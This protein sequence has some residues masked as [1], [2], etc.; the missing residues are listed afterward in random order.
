MC[1]HMAVEILS[2]PNKYQRGTDEIFDYI[3]K[4]GHNMTEVGATVPQMGHLGALAAEGS[5]QNVLEIGFNA[6]CS[7]LAFLLGSSA[8]LHVVS[9][10]IGKHPYVHDAKKFIDGKFPGRHELVIGNSKHTVPKYA[11]EHPG[12]KFD[13]IFIDGGHGYRYAK[14]DL[15]NCRLLAH[16]ST[17]VI[18]DDLVPG[19]LWSKGPTRAWQRAIDG[20]W[21]EEI[22]RFEDGQPVEHIGPNAERGWALGR[23][24]FARN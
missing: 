16:E 23:Y 20:G 4:L 22:G 19:R 7:S 17:T 9:F 14:A 3:Q 18:M 6:G 13:L 10:D 2:E 24:L 8:V 1:Y 11:A 12:R 21:V 15:R 5:V